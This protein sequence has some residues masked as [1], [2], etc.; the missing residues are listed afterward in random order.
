[1]APVRR[2]LSFV[3]CLLTWAGLGLPASAAYRCTAMAGSRLAAPCCPTEL[4]PDL[5]RTAIS[6]HCCELLTRP[7]LDTPGPGPSANK[8]ASVPPPLLTVLAMWVPPSQSE[9]PHR[10]SHSFPKGV[11]PNT[12]LPRTGVT[13]LQL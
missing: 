1:M 9:L 4:S 6:D 11:P 5:T 13:V 3:L 8:R 7:S 2:L 12:P 10:R